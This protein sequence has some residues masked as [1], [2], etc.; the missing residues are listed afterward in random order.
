MGGK[1]TVRDSTAKWEKIE[2]KIINFEGNLEE[3]IKRQHKKGKGILVWGPL[4]AEFGVPEV[5]G[6]K[7]DP[8]SCKVCLALELHP[9]IFV[10]MYACV[11][12]EFRISH[13]QGKALYY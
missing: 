7:P 1:N 6:I 11:L 12:V 13:T 10:C 3:T 8:L 2:G 4:P 9:F 5:S